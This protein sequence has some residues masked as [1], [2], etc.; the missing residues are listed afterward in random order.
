MVYEAKI[1]S[2][3]RK[4]MKERKVLVYCEDHDNFDLISLPASSLIAI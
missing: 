1:Q 2:N 4:G 3:R